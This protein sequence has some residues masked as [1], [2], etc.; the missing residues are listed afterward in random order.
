MRK[1]ANQACYDLLG[2]LQCE[3]EVR[4]WPHHFDTGIYTPINDQLG[5]GFGLAMR[6]EMVGAPYLYFSAYGLNDHTLDYAEFEPLTNGHWINQDWKG[7]VLPFDYFQEEQIQLF[8]K[9]VT[10]RIGLS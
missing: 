5:I 7:A 8:L 1:N 10:N 3:S 9:E 2:Y 6:D 4:I